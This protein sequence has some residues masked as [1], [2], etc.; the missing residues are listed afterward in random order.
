MMEKP[1]IIAH[2]QKNL[3]YTLFDAKWVPRSARFVVV[4]SHARGTGALQVYELCQGEVKLLKEV[5]NSNT[6]LVK[7]SG[8]FH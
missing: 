1:Q 2:I 8:Q 7:V 3:N 4:G 6:P 5:R